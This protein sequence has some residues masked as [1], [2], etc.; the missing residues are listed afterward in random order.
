MIQV[1]YVIHYVTLHLCLNIFISPKH[2]LSFSFLY[3][4]LAIARTFSSQKVIQKVYFFNTQTNYLQGHWTT[5]RNRMVN[6][7]LYIYFCLGFSK[8]TRTCYRL[9]S[10][11]INLEPLFLF[12]IYF[13]FYFLLVSLF[14]SMILNFT[15]MSVKCGKAA[16]LKN[17][18][19][20]IHN[21]CPSEWLYSPSRMKDSRQINATIFKGCHYSQFYMMTFQ[22][23]RKIETENLNSDPCILN[24]LVLRTASSAAYQLSKH[25]KWS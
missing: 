11:N 4:V 5:C 14:V 12:Q 25:Q 24:F 9:F 6:S 15:K 3:T 1:S 10:I 19:Q 2:L 7:H 16:I 8:L 23:F 18:Y 20:L 17:V 13:E 21:C 22:S